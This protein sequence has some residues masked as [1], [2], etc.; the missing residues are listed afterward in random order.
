MKK[1]MNLI[2]AA[3]L[4]V[5][6]ILASAAVSADGHPTVYKGVDYA[7]VYDYDYFIKKYPGLARKYNY[8][9]EKILKSFVLSGM[10]AGRRGSASFSVKSYRYGNAGLRRYYGTDL[11]KY[12]LHYAKRGYRNE[13]RRATATGVTLMRDAL[14]VY[15]GVDYSR[16][17][18]YR[19][20]TSRY[21]SVIAAV[22]DDDEAVLK[23]FVKSG[24]KKKMTADNTAK[25]PDADPSSAL[26][27]ELF[28]KTLYPTG[29]ALPKTYVTTGTPKTWNE[30]LL[31]VISETKNGGGYYTG[32]RKDEEHPR[33]TAEGL[34]E[35]FA[36]GKE[37]VSI[38]LSKAR[39]SYCSSA[40][41]MVMLKTLLMW[42]Q[43]GAISEKAWE[44]LRPYPQKGMAYPAQN[45][46]VG[47]WGRANANGPGAA[48]LVRELKAGKN[49][50]IGAP[51]EYKKA[52][53][54]WN[55]WA[56]AEPGDLLKIFRTKDIGTKERGHMVVYLGHR[57]ALDRD[58]KRDDVIYYWSSQSSTD[59]YGIASC[60]A[61]EIFRAVLTK[62]KDPAA[63]DNA[64]TIAP[65]D[66]D[67]WLA[68]LI[69]GHNAGAKEMIAK[70]K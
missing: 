17:Y 10:K 36:M 6:V 65:T 54:Y 37:G 24:M 51:S 59:G 44:N 70:L 61:S 45:D 23:Y 49:L 42:D 9:D 19:Y 62:V 68:S 41:Y 16:I 31:R 14:T 69:S 38:D 33:T 13:K 21:P 47:C 64:K 12:Y 56:K 11:V 20:F 27:Q 4:S 30:I 46:G 50:Y 22:G 35:A 63:F 53:S 67:P 28:R 48:V 25:K 26:Y 66:T 43:S 58:G 2:A 5:L 57:Y 18:S 1:L 55:A 8:D 3:V 32:S 52:G 34:A 7:P 39:P 60:P 40:V 29:T 15:E